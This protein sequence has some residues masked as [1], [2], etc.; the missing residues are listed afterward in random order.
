MSGGD[1]FPET[2]LKAANSVPGG[3][4][5]VGVSGGADSVALLRLLA[6]RS[7]LKLHVIHVDHQL[8]G[9]ASDDDARFVGEMATRLNLPMTLV[10]RTE[11]A[12]GRVMETP[13]S[14]QLRQLRLAV[15][16]EAVNRH[17]LAGVCLAH[18]A[19]DLIETVLLRVLRGSPR[20]G[21]LG[22]RPLRTT[23]DLAGLHVC[24][25]LLGIRRDR[26]RQWLLRLGQPWREDASNA[27]AGSARNR[28]RLMLSKYPQASAAALAFARAAAAS[29]NWFDQHTTGDFADETRPL[30]IRRRL[31]RQWLLD[32]GVPQADASPAAVDRLLSMLDP[33]SPR[34]IEFPGRVRVERKRG[35]IISSGP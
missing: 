23:Q 20:S 12:I 26:L 35:R 4:W 28:L 21:T 11:H 29:E 32:H 16:G 14:A 34:V 18:H 10:R 22:L 30:P 1:D 15:F 3:R 8:R 17:D 13:S 9:Q 5:A 27:Q 19:D 24:R 33:T 7:E 25:P 6:R 31:A 2:L